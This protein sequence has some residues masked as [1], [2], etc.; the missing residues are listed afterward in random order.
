MLNR[1]RGRETTR[2][3]RAVAICLA[4]DCTYRVLKVHPCEM[5]H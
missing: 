4:L 2:D 5:A 3:P 1:L